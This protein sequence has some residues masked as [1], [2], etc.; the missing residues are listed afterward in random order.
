MLHIIENSSSGSDKK[1]ILEQII[2]PYL[3]DAGESYKIYLS[4]KP[5]DIARIAAEITASDE[6]VRILLLGGDGSINELLSGI[7]DTKKV[8]LSLIPT[9]SGNDFARSVGIPKDVKLALD[10][11]VKRGRTSIIDL[12][13]ITYDDGTSRKFIISSGIGFDAAVCE[14]AMHSKLKK[15]LNKIKLGKL[16]YGL[17]AIKQIFGADRPDGSITFDGDEEIPLK[18]VLFSAFMNEPFEGGGFKFGPRASHTDG[19]LDIC[20]VDSIPRLKFFLCLPFA[21][22]GKHFMFS[23]VNEYRASRIHVH[24]TAPMWVH[25]DGEV[26]RQASDIDIRVLRS[27]INITM[28]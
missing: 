7:R 25:T 24:L 26:T 8:I 21:F 17:I 27:A 28:P 3:S 11:A 12:G 10:I 22:S 16:S 1:G 13:E 9:G 2:K 15:S 4:K 6:T 14:E 18:K 19:K 23:H 5:G 20:V